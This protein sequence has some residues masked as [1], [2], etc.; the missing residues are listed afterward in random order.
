MTVQRNALKRHSTT[1]GV[2]IYSIYMVK[3]SPP[4]YFHPHIRFSTA[5]F[6]FL[7]FLA[8]TITCVANFHIIASQAIPFLYE[9]RMLLDWSCTATTLHLGEWYRMED[10]SGQLFLNR[11]KIQTM[12][13]DTRQAGQAQPLKRKLLTGALLVVL[14][15]FVLWCP[16]LIMSLV[17]D[18]ALPNV[19]EEVRVSLSVNSYQPLFVMD[20]LA[21]NVSIAASDFRQL[22]HADTSG[23]VKTYKQP[24]VQRILLSPLSKSL[25]DISPS[26]RTRLLEVL[27]DPEQPVQLTF[28]YV[29]IRKPRQGVAEKAEGRLVYAPKNGTLLRSSL[30]E[31]LTSSKAVQLPRFF[32]SVYQLTDGDAATTGGG[33]PLPLGTFFA[34]A[35]LQRLEDPNDNNRE[36]WSL[37]QTS[38]HVV[39]EVGE[40]PIACLGGAICTLTLSSSREISSLYYS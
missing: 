3:P 39:S 36:Y 35:E 28:S 6:R 15:I 11:H 26:S 29:F 20:T 12:A 8:Y 33:L 22:A 21:S 27:Q 38:P 31:A 34:D 7:L 14:L 13:E 23:F 30:Y 17:N 2:T 32:P 19:P 9:L 40:R 37:Q 25:W 5:L 10:I 1:L 18:S 16:L 24:D 4:V